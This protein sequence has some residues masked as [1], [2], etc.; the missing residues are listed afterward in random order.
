MNLKL[1]Q[2]KKI[3]DLKNAKKFLVRITSQKISK[4][5]ALELYS[6]LI[7]PDIV[8]LE[9]A[10]GKGKNKRCKILEVLGNLKSVFTGVYLHYKDVPSESEESIAERAKL[11]RKKTKI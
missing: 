7:A 10:K 3:C 1:L 5:E 4:E 6:D 11:R 9:N 8:E 2:T